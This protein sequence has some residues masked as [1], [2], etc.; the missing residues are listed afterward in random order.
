MIYTKILYKNFFEGMFNLFFAFIYFWSLFDRSEAKSFFSTCVFL[1]ISI[2]TLFII[3]C[4]ISF[5]SSETEVFVDVSLPLVS[6]WFL[7]SWLW[8]SL[9]D[10][11]FSWSSLWGFP[12][13][14]GATF[15]E[16]CS[17]LVL[18]SLASFTQSSFNCLRTLA[19]SDSSKPS[20]IFYITKL[21]NYQ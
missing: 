5:S 10:T 4:I 9:E 3:S 20:L 7:W 13:A 8:G 15:F 18:C 16:V 19:S 11:I 2:S 21:S 17:F 12:F 1:F 6:S 14:W